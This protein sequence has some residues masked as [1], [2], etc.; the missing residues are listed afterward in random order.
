MKRKRTDRLRNLVNA[1]D[2]RLCLMAGGGGQG[3]K[4]TQYL[5]CYSSVSTGGTTKLGG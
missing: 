5:L 2:F 1:R 3:C 4:G